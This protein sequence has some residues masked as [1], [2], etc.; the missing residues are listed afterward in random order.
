MRL[1]PAGPILSVTGQDYQSISLA[2]TDISQPGIPVIGYQIYRGLGSS[3]SSF[4][5]IATVGRQLTYVDQ[6]LSPSTTYSY[7]VVGIYQP[8]LLTSPSNIVTDTTAAAIPW[9]YAL[10]SGAMDIYNVADPAHM[11]LNNSDTAYSQGSTA[12]QQ[13]ADSDYL[14]LANDGKVG[15]YRWSANPTAPTNPFLYSHA[16]QIIVR[17]GLTNYN[18]LMLLWVGSPFADI[19][20]YTYNISNPASPTQLYHSTGDSELAAG[21][22]GPGHSAFAF[23]PVG[24]KLWFCTAWTGYK[25]EISYFPIASDGT[26]GAMNT[27]YQ[28]IW[29]G[30]NEASMAFIYN[31]RF[32][33]NQNQTWLKSYYMNGGGEAM[34]PWTWPGAAGDFHYQP[35]RIVGGHYAIFGADGANAAHGAL[36]VVD[37]NTMTVVANIGTLNTQ[38]TSFTIAGPYLFYVTGTTLYAYN[39]SNP[40]SP[41][42]VSSLGSLPASAIGLTGY[43]STGWDGNNG[44]CTS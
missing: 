26:I 42:L 22:K 12:N 40:T 31:G 7:Y 35:P 14:Y 39:I 17:R 28:T 2:W 44:L 24:G 9:L 33:Y 13:L 34:T 37:L 18:N 19:G 30:S 23:D 43:A 41:S 8:G 15:I 11:S 6:G 10:R 32:W 1:I 3:P 16:S 27:M 38:C 25:Y 5:L 21:Q 20:I 36:I 4:S 29:G